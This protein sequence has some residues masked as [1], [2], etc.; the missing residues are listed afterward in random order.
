MD[1]ADPRCVTAPWQIDQSGRHRPYWRQRHAEQ[2]VARRGAAR[3]RRRCDLGPGTGRP[4]HEQAGRF[5]CDAAA[6]NWLARQRHDFRYKCPGDSWSGYS[7]ACR[8]RS[9][10]SCAISI[11]SAGRSYNGVW[12]RLFMDGHSLVPMLLMLI[13][14]LF[15]VLGPDATVPGRPAVWRA[16]S[17]RWLST[18][19][20]CATL[21][22]GVPRRAWPA[23]LPDPPCW[24]C[25][26][27]L[28]SVRVAGERRRRGPAG[29]VSVPV[30]A[31]VAVA[32][33]A[34]R[35]FLFGGVVGDARLS[36]HRPQAVRRAA[37]GRS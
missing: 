28:Y 7:S 24:R 1:P 8:R 11:A 10:R 5:R 36:E 4:S 21:S 12:Q 3:P 17:P 35:D 33:G 14:I 30:G 13:A 19:C 25:R 26:A 20:S 9:T 15:S 2:R 31:G 37:G 18:G 32:A 22:P 6:G 16:C 29:A 34:G 23:H 27:A